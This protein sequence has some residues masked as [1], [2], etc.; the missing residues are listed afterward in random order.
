MG[1]FGD[2]MVPERIGSTVGVGVAEESLTSW[3]EREG[4]EEGVY[5]DS[6][7]VGCWVQRLCRFGSIRVVFHCSVG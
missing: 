2:G 4:E 3:R 6:I 7:L 1:V 5:K